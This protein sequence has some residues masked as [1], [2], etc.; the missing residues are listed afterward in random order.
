M[1]KRSR[2]GGMASVSLRL[3][4]LGPRCMGAAAFRRPLHLYLSNFLPLPFLRAGSL[5]SV[6]EGATA[7]SGFIF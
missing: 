4:P 7:S 5:P 2:G 3:A 1:S 6:A